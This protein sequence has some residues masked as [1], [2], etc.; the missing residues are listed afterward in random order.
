MSNRLYSNRDIHKY[1]KGRARKKRPKTFKSKESAAKYAESK[2]IENYEL[3][4]LRFSEK[5]PK[6]RI[7][8]KSIK[9]QAL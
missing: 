8:I 9:S 6:Y 4:N 3:K 2:R 5:K 7:I 1:E